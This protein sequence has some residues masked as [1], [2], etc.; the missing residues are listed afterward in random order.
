M[1]SR[2]IQLATVA[3]TVF[4][5]VKGQTSTSCNPTE[6]STC[7][8]DAALGKTVTI[9]FTQGNSS[10]FTEESG[11]TVTYGDNGAE[12][13]L[14]SDGLAKT[15]V[16]TKYIMFGRVNVTMKAAP[17]TGVISCLVM[18]SDD[19]DEIDWEWLGGNTTVVESN[20]FGKGNTTS[21]N[22]AIYHAVNDPQDEWHMYTIDWTSARTN[23]YIDSVLVR[24]LLYADA[25]D[26]AN[27]PQTPMN[28]K[29]GIWDGGA[30]DE[31]TGTVEWA[32]GYTD[33]TNAPFTMY[34]KNMTIEDYT[35]GGD[36]Y[37]YSDESG[38]Y[39]SIVVSNSTDGSSATVTSASGDTDS[40]SSSNGTSSSSSSSTSSTSSTS[41]SSSSGASTT[42]S[43][44]DAMQA[45]FAQGRK[46]ALTLAGLGIGMF[47]I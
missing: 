5:A 46:L 15:V 8:S 27:Y 18:E 9:D 33:L 25:L 41:S 29:L 24:T 22:R 47:F 28:I 42:S 45:N 1:V 7:P 23:W 34:V 35:T 36:T 17:G 2:F 26:G 11:T 19:L 6:N 38:S 20:Y 37:T 14:E 30:A 4:Q 39:T 31:S 43:T 13:I 40:S 32:G 3:L 12:F 21:Y 16:S 10:Y 44:S